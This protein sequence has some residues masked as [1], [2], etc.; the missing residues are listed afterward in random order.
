M[1]EYVKLAITAAILFA[2]LAVCI[3]FSIIGIKNWKKDK[4]KAKEQIARRTEMLSETGPEMIQVQATV[5]DQNFQVK[6][7]GMKT[8][9][10]ET[11]FVVAF[12]TEDARTLTFNIPEEMYHG[13]DV[14]QKGQLT[15]VD[16]CLYGFEPENI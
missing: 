10:S 8:P 1:E 7:V 3:V 14:G 16:D 6:L 5:I 11:V 13:L 4:E 15:Y 12:R 9:K 2:V